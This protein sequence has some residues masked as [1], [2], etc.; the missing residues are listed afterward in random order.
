MRV[1]GALNE[2]WK[3]CPVVV[4]SFTACVP[5]VRCPSQEIDAILLV[6]TP[7][8]SAAKELHA[9]IICDSS[10][11]DEECDSPDWDQ[12]TT[13]VPD[14]LK[15]ALKC[16][17]P[18]RAAVDRMCPVNTLALIGKIGNVAGR[19]AK[20]ARSI[21]VEGRHHLRLVR[22]GCRL[23]DSECSKRKASDYD[24]HFQDIASWN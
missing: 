19:Q 13:C 18:R 17:T 2:H 5:S 7:S 16:L 20:M 14:A 9:A 10:G 8:R 11:L 22:S 21:S 3:V 15:R 12:L 6:E 1:P 24:F 23:C 4:L